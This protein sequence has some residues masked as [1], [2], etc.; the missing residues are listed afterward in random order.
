M[1]DESNSG[2]EPESYSVFTNDEEIKKYVLEYSFKQTIQRK[3]NNQIFIKGFDEEFV[4]AFNDIDLCMRVRKLGY[5]V[6]YNPYAKFYHYESKS[7]GLE[8]TKEKVERFNNETALFNY[9]WEQE[10]QDGDRYYNPNLTLRKSN[11]ALR[12]LHFEE[13]GAP[14][15]LPDEIIEKVRRLKDERHPSNNSSI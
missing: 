6:V 7:R 10:M 8:D 2:D 5:L 3:Y 11:F 15:K 4:V 12:D 9:M 1:K 14:Y 13:I